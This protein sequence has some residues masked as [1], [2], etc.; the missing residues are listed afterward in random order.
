[1]DL[2]A[3]SWTAAP[4][5]IAVIDFNIW[6]VPIAPRFEEA[7]AAMRE[8]DGFVL[9]LRGNPGGVAALAQGIAGYFVDEPSS[10]GTLR[11]R[12]SE[13]ERHINPRLVLSPGERSAPFEGPRAFLVDS[14]TGST[15]EISAA[16]LK[17]PGRPR[18]FGEPTAG[19]ALPAQAKRLP[20]GDVLMHATGDFVRPSGARIEGEPDVHFAHARGF[21]AKTSAAEM[22]RLREL[23]AGSQV[24]TLGQVADA[25]RL[26]AERVRVIAEGAGAAPLAVA[27][28]ASV[29]PGRP[30]GKKADRPEKIVCVVSGGNIDLAKFAQLI[31]AP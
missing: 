14:G 8:A 5:S 10:L 29:T 6:M 22:P 16:G 20:S 27:L 30:P 23:L 17:A 26:L 28:T 19:A 11:A 21:V 15:S 24:V 31:S 13:L 18:L 9:D 3:P 7:V 12:R 1:M 2:M 4:T 25:I